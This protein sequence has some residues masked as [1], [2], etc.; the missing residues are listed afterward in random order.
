MNEFVVL[1]KAVFE[2]MNDNF[3]VF[4]HDHVLVLLSFNLCATMLN[5]KRTPTTTKKN[6]IYAVDAASG[7][8]DEFIAGWLFMKTYRPTATATASPIESSTVF[9]LIL[10]V[11]PS[12]EGT[13]PS[14]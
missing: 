13:R 14:P 10:L 12:D 9:V 5:T 11:G 2:K 8:A 1:P 4:Y 6:I 3:I 7:D